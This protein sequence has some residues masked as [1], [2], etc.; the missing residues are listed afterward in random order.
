[1]SLS[2]WVFLVLSWGAI[3]ALT[4]FCLSRTFRKKA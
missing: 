4:V 3:L 1:M 2:G